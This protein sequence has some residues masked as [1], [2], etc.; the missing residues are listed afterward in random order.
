MKVKAYLEITM[1]I[2]DENRSAAA[3]VFFKY[4]EEF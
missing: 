4:K 2:A 3:N 1:Q